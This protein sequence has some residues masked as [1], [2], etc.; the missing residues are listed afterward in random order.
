ATGHYF[1][2]LNPLANPYTSEVKNFEDG[3][4]YTSEYGLKVYKPGTAEL[5]PHLSALEAFVKNLE[6]MRERNAYTPEGADQ[7]AAA[8][9]G[10]RAVAP[11]W[12]TWLNRAF[13]ISWLLLLF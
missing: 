5:V 13:W 7:L 4:V 1:P 11:G 6:G 10:E 9:G 2:N 3:R 8:F 12:V